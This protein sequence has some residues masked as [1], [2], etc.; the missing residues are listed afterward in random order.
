MSV[1]GPY[2]SKIRT[3]HDKV[4]PEK[5]APIQERYLI[6]QQI[7]AGPH[8]NVY[9]AFDSMRRNPV[10]L[11]S[12]PPGTEPD[13]LPALFL[14]HEFFIGT[15]IG[16]HENLIFT[17]DFLEHGAPEGLGPTLVRAYA[18]GGDLRHWFWQHR[19][20]LAYRRNEG[21][22]IIVGICKGLAAALRA[23]ALHVDIKPENV[24]MAMGVPKVS[25]WGA[26]FLIDGSA[27]NLDPL[28]FPPRDFCTPAYMSPEHLSSDSLEQLGIPSSIFSIGI[29]LFE[30]LSLQGE[31]PFEAGDTV[32]LYSKERSVG[33]LEGVSETLQGVVG[34]CLAQNPSDRYQSFETLI[35]DLDAQIRSLTPLEMSAKTNSPEPAS[36][37]AASV[38]QKKRRRRGDR[39]YTHIREN[40][41]LISLDDIASLL[42]KAEAIN[43]RHPALQ[44]LRRRLKNKIAA[45]ADHLAQARTLLARQLN[46]VSVYDVLQEA[47]ALNPG[48]PNLEFALR[49]LHELK[50]QFRERTRE[51]VQAGMGLEL[52]PGHPV[53]DYHCRTGANAVDIIL[54]T[55]DSEI[56]KLAIE[57]E[58]HA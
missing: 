31:L 26:A 50:T 11:K 34:L 29:I 43:G 30:M 4:T 20:N 9:R 2:F 32:R 33:Q 40:F 44:R 36:P 27:H 16:E 15:H 45:Y 52:R 56:A 12:W 35:D 7:H 57:E 38:V 10:A 58:D 18:D 41:D 3:G 19:S 13:D 5:S 39:Q 21:L 47:L 6:E 51:S 17:Y 49:V 24:L 1:K 28:R 46:L 42:E 23:G 22:S 8:S 48:T 25:D 37:P 53:F 55:I 54:K 14:E